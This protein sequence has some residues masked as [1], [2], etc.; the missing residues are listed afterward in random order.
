MDTEVIAIPTEF[1]Y[2]FRYNSTWHVLICCLC[3][4]IVLKKTVAHHLHTYHPTI[5][6]VEKKSLKDALER[7]F[8]IEIDL[9]IQYP[10]NGTDPIKGLSIHDALKCIVCEYVTKS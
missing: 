4:F 5:P 9:E 7:L 3:K 10:D 6:K 8:L 2:L 1:E